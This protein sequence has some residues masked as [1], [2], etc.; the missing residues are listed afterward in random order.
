MSAPTTM[1]DLAAYGLVPAEAVRSDRAGGGPDIDTLNAMVG[2]HDTRALAAFFA[3]LPIAA[4]RRI[5]AIAH[6]GT[7]A[8]NDDSWLRQWMREEPAD[9]TAMS[10]SAESLIVLAWQ[11]RTASSADNVTREQWIGFFRVL[12][13]VP[14]L[15]ARATAIDPADPAP[16]IALETAARGLQWDNDRFRPLWAEVSARAPHSFTAAH[17]AWSYWRPRWYG[18]VEALEDFTE[19]VIAAAPLGSNLSAL[20]LEMLYDELKPESTPDRTAFWHS[21]RVNHALSYAIQDAA[22]SDPDHVKLPYLR[23]LL[24]YQLYLADRPAEAIEQFR[25]I[26]GF[27]GAMPWDRF[28]DP[29]AKFNE[30]RVAVIKEHLGTADLR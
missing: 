10:V 30:V 6:L 15:C 13:Q 5:A 17:R 1:V 4:E 14:A 29:A 2:A 9:V 28:K 27:C 23:H 21:D 19:T 18:S 16:F 3:P 22:A 12:N 26:G 7:A 24:A 11:I 20:R 8:G 25:A